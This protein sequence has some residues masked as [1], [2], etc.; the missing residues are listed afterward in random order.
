MTNSFLMQVSDALEERQPLPAPT[1]DLEMQLR[2]ENAALRLYLVRWY[3][4]MYAPL[5][6]KMKSTSTGLSSTLATAVQVQGDVT[7]C[8]ENLAALQREIQ[9]ATRHFHL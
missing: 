7:R 6:A 5:Q 3:D 9:S 8:C 4:S 2:A 1:N